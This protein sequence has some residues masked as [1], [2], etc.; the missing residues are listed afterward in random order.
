VKFQDKQAVNAGIQ[1]DVYRLSQ[2]ELGCKGHSNDESKNIGE[3]NE[4]K[5]AEILQNKHN[6]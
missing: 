5:N 3:L 6:R 4:M 2:K 1:C